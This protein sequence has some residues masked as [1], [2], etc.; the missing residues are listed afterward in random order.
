MSG[1]KV[2]PNMP[3]HGYSHFDEVDGGS[4]WFEDE[5]FPN[6]VMLSD[7]VRLD[8]FQLIYGD[9]DCYPEFEL[10]RALYVGNYILRVTP[11][12][13]DDDCVDCLRLNVDNVGYSTER[14]VGVSLD[15]MVRLREMGYVMEDPILLQ[16]AKHVLFDLPL[17]MRMTPWL[18]N[19]RER[20]TGVLGALL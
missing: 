11:G 16:E 3:L 2:F 8:S 20:L 19:K 14:P 6:I 5:D 13:A 15:R 7:S 9:E 1:Q 4:Y 12:E 10:N 18:N 17:S